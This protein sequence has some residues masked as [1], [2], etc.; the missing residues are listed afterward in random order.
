LL[1][2]RVPVNA[3]Q[4]FSCNLYNLLEHFWDG[5]AGNFKLNRDDE[6]IQSCLVTHDG[7]IICPIAKA[8]LS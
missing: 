1:E 6:I 4:M 7:K 5:D 3:S 2:R 8:A